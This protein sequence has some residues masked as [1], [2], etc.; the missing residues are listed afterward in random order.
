MFILK[1][2][3]IQNNKNSVATFYSTSN[4]ADVS[5]RYEGRTTLAVDPAKL[6]SEL[7]LTKVTM[8]DNGNF[9][10]T[11][12]I[13]DDDE[14]TPSASTSVLVLVPPSPPIC[15][16]QGK[17]E[18]WNN[19]TLTCMSEEG[20]PNPLYEWKSYSVDN[21]PRSFPPKTTE[22]HGVLSLFN[23]SR[24]FSGFFICTSTNQIASSSCNL[25][26]AVMPGSMSGATAGII[27][28]VIAA[29]LLLAILIFCCCRK[30][31][32]KAKYTEGYEIHLNYLQYK[33]Q[34]RGSHDRLDDNRDHYRGSR[35]RLDDNRD[36]Y[37]GSSDRLDDNRDHYRGSRD[38]LDDNRDHYR[39]SRDRLDDN[40]DHYRGSSDRLDD[41]RDHYRGSS[42]RLDDHRDRYRGSHDR[43]DD[44][45][46]HYRGSRDRLDDSQHYGSRD[47]LDNSERGRY[48]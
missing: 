37:R 21:R 14:G 38:R 1:W 22:K 46:D 48:D 4:R 43:L 5:P 9:Q 35:D 8:E 12:L 17:A 10:C 25:T 34:H 32:K 39:G 23:I 29:V 45:R 41:N 2:E 26:L 11:V 18:Y 31:N 40:R 16:I 36:R 15:T 19:I 47:H 33:S 6:A 42:D 44:N 20:S 7:H 27:V 3:I 28:G 13:P 30:K 24:E